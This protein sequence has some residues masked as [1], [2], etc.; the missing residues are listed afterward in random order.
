MRRVLLLVLTL[1]ITSCSH[2]KP[3]LS[4]DNFSH[5]QS[6][7]S[8]ETQRTISEVYVYSKTCSYC[9]EIQQEVLT[10]LINKTSYF[11]IEVTNETKRCKSQQDLIS[12]DDFCTIGTPA[13][14]IVEANLITDVYL[15]KR[16]VLD[17]IYK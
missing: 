16:A 11:L 9:K 13:I 8:R 14:L 15:G 6:L 1:L 4:Y 2:S 3:Q 7:D 17:Y 10:Y 12:L 5:Y